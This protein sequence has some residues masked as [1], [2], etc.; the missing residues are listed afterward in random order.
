M[1][2]RLGILIYR[3]Q[4]I[5][6]SSVRLQ[7]LKQLIIVSHPFLEE[8]IKT[9]ED[10]GEIFVKIRHHCT[11]TNYTLLATIAEVFELS[12]ASELIEKYSIEADHYKQKLLDEKFVKELHNGSSPLRDD[13]I[14]IELK[15]EWSNVDYITVKEFKDV[16][17]DVFSKMD[18]YVHLDDVRPGCVHCTCRAPA[19]LEKV[20]RK[21]AEE[22]AEFLIRRGVVSLLIGGVAVL[23]KSEMEN[24]NTDV[25]D[26]SEGDV[27]NTLSANTSMVQFGSCS[28]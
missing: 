2:S 6:E 20:L 22:R 1:R 11:L 24:D 27:L 25:S 19:M 3:V 12:K 18:C 15:L 8:Q 5:A 26:V 21:L 10:I 4:K 9:S 28:N 13:E 23:G 17:R 14:S 16:L 7:D